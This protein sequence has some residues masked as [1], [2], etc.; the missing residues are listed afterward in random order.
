MKLHLTNIKIQ[1]NFIDGRCLLELTHKESQDGVETWES[2]NPKNIFWPPQ[3][4]VKTEGFISIPVNK[5]SF[6]KIVLTKRKI[7]N[8]QI[9]SDHQNENPEPILQNSRRR[10]KSQ[11]QLFDLA[12][13]PRENLKNIIFAF[14]ATSQ[15]KKVVKK[16]RQL[17]RKGRRPFVKIIVGSA[18]LQFEDTNKLNKSRKIRQRFE[19]DRIKKSSR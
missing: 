9:L 2:G 5:G 14:K 6:L 19:I 15:I 16:T 12:K 8:F 4:I 3:E 1:F 10:L 18:L 13:Q 7:L 17:G 11:P